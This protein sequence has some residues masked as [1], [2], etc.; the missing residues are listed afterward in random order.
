MNALL[1]EKFLTSIE[2]LTPQ[3][4]AQ[5]ISQLKQPHQHLVQDLEIHLNERTCCVHCQSKHI[6]R[7]GHRQGRQRFWCHDCHRSFGAT[8]KTAFSGLRD[9]DRWWEY[10][11]CLCDGVTLRRAAARCH[12]TL[13]RAFRW[14]HRFILALSCTQSAKLEGIVEIDE[15]FFK[16]SEK[17]SKRPLPTDKK[18]KLVPIL[19]ACDRS[20]HV[21]DGLLNQNSSAE[22]MAVLK[23]KVSSDCLVCTDG[24][25]AYRAMIRETGA[26]HQIL[27]SCQGKRVKEGTYHIQTVNAYHRRL[28]NWASRFYGVATKYLTH[29]LNWFRFLDRDKNPNE[30]RLLELEQYCT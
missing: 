2:T 8:T 21:V 3:Q 23:D 10:L 28:K 19:V 20:R 7:N 29:Y 16:Y 4:T 17:G 12:I 27:Y 26:T 30:F 15:T 1:F 24:N 18:G 25:A 13:D 14:R 6:K 22:I 9:Q 5:L 11:R